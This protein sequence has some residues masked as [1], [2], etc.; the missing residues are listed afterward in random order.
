MKEIESILTSI[1]D[2]QRTDLYL[3]DNILRE[4]Q[5]NLLNS[6]LARRAKG[7]P[8]QYIMGYTEFMGLKFKVNKRVLIP[9]PETELLVEKALEIVKNKDYKGCKILDMGTG[10]GNIAI[11]LAKFLPESKIVAIDISSVALKVAQD[12]AKLNQ[13]QESIKF[14]ETGLFIT[15]LESKPLTGF[16]DLNEDLEFDMIISNPPYIPCDEISNLAIEVKNEPRIALDGGKDGL[17]FYREIVKESPNYLKT[18][19][20]LIMEM[21]YNQSDSII[22][23]FNDSVQFR[24]IELV[25][26]YNQ[27]DRVI[28][29]KLIG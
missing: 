18:D 28:V 7:E 25:K 2:C 14:L 9:R 26:D 27:I 20:I 17:E 6:M 19:G 16:N 22:D 11:S 24:I 13:V 3:K 15:P 1:L 12:N 4:D 21:G 5:L 23:I 29:A 10:S 8:L